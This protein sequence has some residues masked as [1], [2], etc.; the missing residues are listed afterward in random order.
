MA[1]LRRPRGA[2]ARAVL[3]LFNALNPSWRPFAKSADSGPLPG[4]KPSPPLERGCSRVRTVLPAV[5][6]AA[7]LRLRA[8]QGRVGMEASG[9]KKLFLFRPSHPLLAMHSAV[10]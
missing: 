5:T 4:L 10:C 1:G 9:A 8:G 3:G 2:C 6:A 7:S